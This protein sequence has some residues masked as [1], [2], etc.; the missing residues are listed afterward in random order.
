MHDMILR[1]P[2]GYETQIGEG[3]AGAFGGQRQRIALAR[4]L[5]TAIRSWWC[6]TSPI[7]TSMPRARRR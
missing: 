3:G 6:W 4:A 2:E 5:Y 1:L 7:P